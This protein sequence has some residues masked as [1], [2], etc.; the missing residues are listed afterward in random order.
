MALQAAPTPSS[1]AMA[2]FMGWWTQPAA[3]MPVRRVSY[4]KQMKLES[5][6]PLNSSRSGKFG[7]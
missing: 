3:K 4:G 1:V 7:P 2:M 6:K 5:A